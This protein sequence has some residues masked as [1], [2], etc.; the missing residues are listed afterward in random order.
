MSNARRYDV[1]WS[2]ES[3]PKIVIAQPGDEYA[4]TQAEAQESINEA[5]ADS[6]DEN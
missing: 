4:M 1:D 3:N 2:D 5:L 6:N